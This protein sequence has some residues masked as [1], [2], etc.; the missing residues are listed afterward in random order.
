ME[1]NHLVEIQNESSGILN[2]AENIEINCKEDYCFATDFM[3]NIMNMKQK[4]ST[5]WKEPK[6]QAADAHKA[7]VKKE[8]EMLEPIENC[9]KILRKKISLYITEQKRLAM[10]EEERM[11]KQR[12]ELA[13]KQL[14]EADKM[15]K[16]GNELEATIAEQNAIAI[17]EIETKIED[18]T[19]IDGVS[20]RK[21]YKIIV[22]NPN[23]V[24]AYINGIQIR[25]IDLSAIKKIVKMT[26]GQIKINGIDVEEVQIPII[27]K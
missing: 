24:P 6:K 25:E 20:Y 19:K 2:Q 10:L 7:I 9:E 15:R 13:M 18:S 26:D 23:E 16:E 4:I 3:R 27:K 14:E 17:S 12:E 5:Y 1:D 22:T 21:D 11:K 8:K